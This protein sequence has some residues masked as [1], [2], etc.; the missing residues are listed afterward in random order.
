VSGQAIQ[1]N[2]APVLTLWAAVVAERMGF[3]RDEALTL[4]KCLAGLTAHSKGRR[5]GIYKPAEDGEGRPARKFGLGEEF[6]VQLCGR[7][8]PVRRTD[9][10]VRAVVKDKPVDPQSVRRYLRCKF[11]QDLDAA[12]GA[13]QD[14]AEAFD[15]EELEDRAY[16]LYAKFRPPIPSGKRGWGAKGTL[17]PEQIR[18]L[19]G[20]S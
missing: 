14:L 12:R 13:M 15:P 9:E 7:G 6:F 2:R 18:S 3:S 4:G 10:G 11:G 19:A 20:K 5:L 16:E 17:D 1:I 8:V